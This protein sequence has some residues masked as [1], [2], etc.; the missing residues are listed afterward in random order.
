[1]IE[2]VIKY[3][4]FSYQDPKIENFLVIFWSFPIKRNEASKLILKFSPAGYNIF[5]A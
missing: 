1:M 3:R 2:F 5:F 4:I